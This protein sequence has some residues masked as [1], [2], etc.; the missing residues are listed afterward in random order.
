MRKNL[1]LL[2]TLAGSLFAQ[3][4][5][6]LP[7]PSFEDWTTNGFLPYEEPDTWFGTST[8]CI[9]G[10]PTNPNGPTT[11]SAS[12]IKTND[13][14][15][16]S[17]AAKLV[18]LSN[19]EDGSISEGQLI[20]SPASEGYVDFTSKPKSLTGYYKFNKTG[21]DVISISVTI[22][23][24]T[25]S[26]LLA[27]GTLDLTASKTVYTLF[28][29]P[30]TYISSTITPKDIYLMISFNDDAS[31]HSDFTVDNLAFTYTTTPT[32][33]ATSASAGIKFFP[34]PGKDLISFD[35][36]VKNISIQSAN[37]STVLTQAG[38]STE[39]NISLLD[40]GMYIISYEYNDMLIHDKLIVE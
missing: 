24:Q 9:V 7:N 2:L 30:L 31:I 29:V 25:S 40:K 35:K 37:G 18:N 14:Y 32:V 12:N 20:Y 39:L 36:T 15:A 26:D 4:Q 8:I 1:L 33:T 34:N 38:D 11:C 19:P 13:A 10:T 17:H 28:T 3:A 21:T 5:Q 22:I 6:Q 27:Y 16:G 23:G